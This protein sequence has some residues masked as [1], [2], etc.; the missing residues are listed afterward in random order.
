M[1]VRERSEIGQLRE[2][3][4]NLAIQVAR[5]SQAVE[6]LVRMQEEQTRLR[7]RVAEL[8][9]FRSA[10]LWLTGLVGAGAM[11]R[12]VVAFWTKG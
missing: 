11:L 12:Y 3:V 4:Q 8:E 9:G 5:L 10:V 2:C 7:D 6:P 1:N